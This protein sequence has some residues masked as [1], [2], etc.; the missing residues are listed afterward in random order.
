MGPLHD[1][2]HKIKI[3]SSNIM[4]ATHHIL[5]VLSIMILL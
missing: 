2:L 4:L 3:S 1:I 5:I